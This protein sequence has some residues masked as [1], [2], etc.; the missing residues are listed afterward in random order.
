MHGARQ[1]SGTA[2]LQRSRP[3]C[4]CVKL[5]AGRQAGSNKQDLIDFIDTSIWLSCWNCCGSPCLRPLSDPS[6]RFLLQTGPPQRGKLTWLRSWNCCGL[7]PLAW[8][9]SSCRSIW[10]ICVTINQ[11]PSW[12]TWLRSWNCCG[13]PPPPRV[14]SSYRSIRNFPSNKPKRPIDSNLLTWL[15]SWNCCGLPPPARVAS[16]CSASP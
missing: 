12:F 16:S 6:G 15:R 11:D 4:G 5:A 8:V 3:R 13:L 1:Q 2:V 7:L 9:A 10:Q 14:A